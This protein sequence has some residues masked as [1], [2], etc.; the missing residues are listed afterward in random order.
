MISRQRPIASDVPERGLRPPSRPKSG[1][2]R[3]ARDTDG[4]GKAPG[5]A[6]GS[7]DI[8][9]IVG[10]SPRYPWWKMANS[11]DT[12]ADRRRQLEW[13]RTE[14]EKYIASGRAPAAGLS[15][16]RGENFSRIGESIAV[17]GG[18]AAGVSAALRG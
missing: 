16:P 9:W 12:G 6:C 8:G 11:E 10:H 2:V 3:V 18:S 7:V 14:I 1:L 4:I 17:R 5:R 13:V 15:D